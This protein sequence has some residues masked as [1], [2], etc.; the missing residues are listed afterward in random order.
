MKTCTKCDV[1]K[2]ESE[3]HKRSDNRNLSGVCRACKNGYAKAYRV[4]NKGNIAARKK[5]YYANHK[6]TISDNRKGYYQ[7]NKEAIAAAGKVYYQT[8]KEVVRVRGKAYRATNK[9]VVSERRKAH[10]GV[11]KEVFAAR[12]KAYRQANPDKI[13]AHSTNY[14]DAKRQRGEASMSELDRFVIEEAVALRDIRSEMF[15]GYWHVDHIEPL[16]GTD[17]SGLHNAFNIAVVPAAYNMSKKNKQASAPW[18]M[19]C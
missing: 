14:R 7:D 16:Q 15:G 10:Y 1:S 6:E 13:A 12:M 5:E 19:E 2:D 3:F 17:V 4:S 18:Y 11:N 8:N 9:E